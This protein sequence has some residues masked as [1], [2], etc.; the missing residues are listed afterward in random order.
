VSLVLILVIV[1]VL[2]LLG[3]LFLV[4]RAV[5]GA[6]KRQAAEVRQRYPQAT[7]VV[8]G[9]NFFGQ[10][11]LGARQIRG[12]GTLVLTDTELFFEKLAPR[13]EFHI[14]LTSISAIE[15]P[16]SHLGKSVGRRLL[17]VVFQ[18]ESGAPD[19]IAWFVRDLDTVK[20]QLESALR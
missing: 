11:S 1:G 8:P 16:S 12:N 14:P 3:V 2:I 19:S 10:E 7:L 6:L 13:K 18:A 4:L 20:R 5:S 9:A 17:K 15:T